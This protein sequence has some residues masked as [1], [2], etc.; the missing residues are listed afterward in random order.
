MSHW[1]VNAVGRHRR[2]H[3]EESL[4]SDYVPSHAAPTARNGPHYPAATR[5]GQQVPAEP[6]PVA[7][8]RVASPSRAW[9]GQAY[10][11][12]SQPA[13]AYAQVRS[14]RRRLY[15]V[16]AILGVVV[17]GTSIAAIVLS[18]SGSSSSRYRWSATALAW[19]LGCSGV[20]ASTA[21]SGEASIDVGI[22]PREE[23]L[24]SLDGQ[25]IDIT[26]WASAGEQSAAEAM[27]RSLLR[28]SDQEAYVARGPGWLAGLNDGSGTAQVDVQRRV[29]QT[30]AGRLHGT[31]QHW[32]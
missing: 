24:C 7:H 15:A 26:T 25:I 20:H 3:T 6:D 27:A 1:D 8:D 18:L 19:Q 30:I 5:F 9:Y 11:Y 22:Q 23:V 13:R 29:A 21:P 32:Q 10:P 14:E 2:P 28:S 16:L 17:V 4:A 31:V 12:V